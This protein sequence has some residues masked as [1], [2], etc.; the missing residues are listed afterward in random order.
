VAVKAWEFPNSD[1]TVYSR[2][3]ETTMHKSKKILKEAR[4]RPKNI[5]KIGVLGLLALLS[6]VFTIIVVGQQGEKVQKKEIVDKL[7]DGVSSKESTFELISKRKR[8]REDVSNL[9]SWKS[10]ENFVDARIYE[11]ASPEE[12]AARLLATVNAPTAVISETT[13]L[14]NLGDE[15]YIRPHGAYSKPGRTS[16]FFRKGNVMVSI[17][18]SSP[19][20]AKRFAKHMVDEIDQ[21]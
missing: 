8:T 14:K 11:S 21:P 9:L 16:L 5:S 19:E 6:I 7:G 1:Q 10:G 13:K 4:R 17:Y 20:I 15:A 3:K 2:A 12:A 18:A